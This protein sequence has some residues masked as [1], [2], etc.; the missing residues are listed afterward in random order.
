M[1]KSFLIAIAAALMAAPMAFAHD[2][3]GTLKNYCEDPS[4]WGVAP[5]ASGN[6]IFLGQDGNLAGD[7][8]GDGIVADYDGHIEF[9]FGG[10]WLSAGDD[11]PEC[12][13][14][15]AHHPRFGPFTVVDAVN[16]A[17]TQAFAVASDFITL[18]P[19]PPGE[20]DCGDFESDEVTECVGTCTVTFPEGLDGTYQVY[21][22]AFDTGAVGTVGHIETAVGPVGCTDTSKTFFLLPGGTSGPFTKKTGCSA[23]QITVTQ[24]SVDVPGTGCMNLGVG[25]TTCAITGASYSI[26]AE[27]AGAS[28]SHQQVP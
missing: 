27:S 18:V 15:A 13:P 28:G 26:V 3:A 22:G 7:C 23:V 12:N 21:V 5:P 19:P 17:G 4:E 1:S 2:P 20:P 8:D 6:L 24:G 16:G 10:G 25:T 11:V 9:A 14:E